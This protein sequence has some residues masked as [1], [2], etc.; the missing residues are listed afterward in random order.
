[1][2]FQF[3]AS[4]FLHFA[5]VMLHLH[6]NRVSSVRPEVTCFFYEAG[7]YADRLIRELT[8]KVYNGFIN[9]RQIKVGFYFGLSVSQPCR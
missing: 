5:S 9:N 6:Q 7:S 4:A 8:V 1:M 3:L 2:I